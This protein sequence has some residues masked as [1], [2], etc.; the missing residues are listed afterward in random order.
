MLYTVDA[1]VDEPIMLLNKHIGMDDEEGMGI[2]GSLFQSE[3]LRLDSMGKKRIQ[4]WINS[5]GG[6]VMDAYNIC[7]AILKSKTPVDTYNVGMAASSAGLVFM[8]GRRR[9]MLD[10]ALFMMHMPSGSDN[11]KSLKAI[12]DSIVTGIA[13]KSKI[14]ET[15]V[16]NMMQETTWLSAAECLNKGF[17]TDIEYT[18]DINQKRMPA[19]ANDM[20]VKARWKQ[21]NLIVN[22]LLNNYNN[23]KS[24]S[25][26]KITMKLGLNDAATEDNIIE[27]I[28]RIEDKAYKAETKIIQLED[29]H[30]KDMKAIKDKAAAD[31]KEIENKLN[32]ANDE[33][34]AVKNTLAAKEKE[35]GDVIKVKDSLQKEKEE[36][37]A[38]EKKTKAETMVKEIGV[39]TGRIKDDG[40]DAC[41][42]VIAKWV[43][44][45]IVDME[46]TQK[47]IEA[48]PLNKEAVKIVTDSHTAKLDIP[49]TASYLR[50][51]NKLK[52]EGKA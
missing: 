46:G 24:T 11:D 52:R 22:S 21:A 3:L 2:D 4:V 35:L 51:K 8:S 50:A 14:N 41:K 7:S 9:Y 5:P 19:P 23:K 37:I 1:S 16:K 12:A 6:V 36:A 29:Q 20:E 34:S 32:T 31:L 33:L 13:A 25:M 28:K 44:L 39:D 27:E 10:S 42:Q 38:A 30:S 26:T 49:T 18:R 45:A 40:S 43:D 15:E 47:M 48:I 17:C